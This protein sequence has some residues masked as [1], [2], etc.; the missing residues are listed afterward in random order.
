MEI[1]YFRQMRTHRKPNAR[2]LAAAG[3]TGETLRNS[4]RPSDFLDDN[5]T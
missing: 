4:I 5:M 2:L 3:L 1:F